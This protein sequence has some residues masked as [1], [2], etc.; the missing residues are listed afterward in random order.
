MSVSARNN[1]MLTNTGKHIVR[2]RLLH[3]TDKSITLL[4]WFSNEELARPIR[5]FSYYPDELTFDPSEFLGL[6]EQAARELRQ[7]RDIEYLRS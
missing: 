7:K 5:L 3:N 6:T 2:A 1:N 4:V